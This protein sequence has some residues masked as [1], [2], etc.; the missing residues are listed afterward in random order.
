MPNE[1]TKYVVPDLKFET[2]PSNSQQLM[3]NYVAILEKTNQ[4]LGMW[5]NPYG[6]AI[7]VLSLFIAIIAIGVAV[8]LW[9]NS[10]EQKDRFNQFLSDQEKIIK[11]KGESIRKYESKLDVLIKEYETQLK[12]TGEGKKE[13]E[14]ALN[15]LK[16]EKASIDAYINPGA[17]LGTISGASVSSSNLPWA[18]T[19][20]SPRSLI[21]SKCG[22]AFTYYNSSSLGSISLTVTQRVYCS[23]CG[24]LN[25]T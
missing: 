13:I 11:L 10:K 8:A 12:S 3:E 2:A 14:K 17:A 7:G 21:C 9:L 22:K 5:S 18:L 24:H 23:Y 1:A 19:V 6:I 25:I 15:E 16:R 20:E 4:Q